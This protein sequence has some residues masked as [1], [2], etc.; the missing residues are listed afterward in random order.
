MIPVLL[1]LELVLV[2]AVMLLI[3][4]S[5][6]MAYGD[7]ELES[8]VLQATITITTITGAAASNLVDDAAGIAVER[9]LPVGFT[10]KV[11]MLEITNPTG[12]QR[13]VSVFA[14]DPNAGGFERV[15]LGTIIVAANTTVN[16]GLNDVKRPWRKVQ[17]DDITNTPVR[18]LTQLR[19]NQD[20]LPGAGCVLTARYINS[21]YP[22]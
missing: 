15:L 5:L 4:L 22:Y 12:A 3:G 21:K 20:A 16:V 7:L 14:A 11:L 9:E 13:I 10:K 19:A 18:N 6:I 2:V 17:P 1:M 8:M